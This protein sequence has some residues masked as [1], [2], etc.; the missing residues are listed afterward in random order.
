M[1]WPEFHQAQRSAPR[2]TGNPGESSCAAAVASPLPSPGAAVAVAPNGASAPLDLHEG[3][4]P[5]AGCG[6]WPE[7]LRLRNELTG[8]LVMGRCKS[9]NLCRYCQALYV[10]ET[11]EML[12][13]D[14][15]EW[16]PNIWLVLTAREHLT[17]ADTYRHLEHLRRVTKRRWPDIEWFVQV[18]FQ[19]RGA[20]HLNLLIKGVPDGDLAQLHE[21]LVGRWC[22]R[23][24]AL[25]VGQWSGLIRD[26]GGVSRY[27][28]KT[29]A[30]GLKRE[31]APPLGWKGHR[32]SQTRGYFVA[33]A[34]VMRRR[35]RESLA[36]KRSIWRLTKAGHDAHD[37][38]LLT[39]QSLEERSRA[40]WV[41][42]TDR[43]AALAGA[44]HDVRRSALRRGRTWREPDLLDSL[45]YLLRDLEG[46]IPKPPD[47][48]PSIEGLSALLEP[49]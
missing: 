39:R 2:S 12:A 18:E 48:Q 27:L 16:A 17:R 1:S 25:P 32:T 31:Q 38:E 4:S 8:E 6:R 49:R 28:Q 13:L 47:R 7:A 26:A 41:L 3:I 46:A 29:L 43:G 22:D 21:L 9:T 10:V 34:A 44:V 30:H 19:R 36:H 40:V 37:V 5:P 20:L 24:D 23:V 35:A 14:A 11:L 42:A 15:A 33:S 45:R